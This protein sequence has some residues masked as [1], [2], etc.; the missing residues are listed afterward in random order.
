[1]GKLIFALA[2]LT[3]SLFAEINFTTYDKA[4]EMA[5]KENKIVM[6]M[7]GRE[8]CGVCNYMKKNV[9][10][11]E[12][13]SKL[14]NKSFV[15]TYVELGFDDVPDNLQYIGTPT[16]HFLDKDHKKVYRIDGGKNVKAFVKA[17]N[18]IN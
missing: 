1:M 2:L 10:T 8:S 13:V 16:F 3:S 14:F 5:A 7:L 17:L 4:F 9:F 18:S 15:A 12:S 6:I 11:D